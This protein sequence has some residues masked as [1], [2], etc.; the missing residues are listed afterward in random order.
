MTNAV[1][2]GAGIACAISLARL[3]QPAGIAPYISID[4]PVVALTHVGVVDGT[5][6][7]ARED[8][9]LVLR[10]PRIEAV[11]P[12]ASTQPP[13]GA[14]VIDLTGHTVLPGFVGLHEHTYFGGV[15]RMT[16]MRRSGP[17]LYLAYGVTSAMTAG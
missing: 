13:P 6:A 16:Q 12:S 4:A 3:Q 8:Q 9:T 10:G 5:G 7:P 11:G 17:P 1:Y 2:L 14:R 15:K